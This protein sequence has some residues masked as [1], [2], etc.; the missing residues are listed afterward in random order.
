MLRTRRWF[1]WLL[2]IALA[3]VL[4]TACGNDE[5]QT[6]NQAP[7]QN[8]EENDDAGQALQGP[9]PLD[10]TSE[11]IIAEYAGGEVTEGEFNR[12]LNVLSLLD[13]RLSFAMG[14]AEVKK[15]LLNQYMAQELIAEREATTDEMEQQIDEYMDMMK[16]QYE[17]M[18]EQENQD[19]AGWLE[20]QG[21]NEEA[22]RLFMLNST[23][24]NN[25]LNGEVTDEDLQASYD[26]LSERD[27][28]SLY[29][30]KVRHI[31]IEVNEERDAEA[32]KERAEEVK[33]K[34]AEG[35][36][37]SELAK[38]FSDDGSSENGGLL[39]EEPQPLSNYVL[40]FAQTARDLALDEISEPVQSQFGFHIIDVEERNKI[41]FAEAKDSAQLRNAALD[42]V[43]E[44]FVEDEL[45][46][47][48]IDLPGTESAEA[49][50]GEEADDN[51]A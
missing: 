25:Y 21:V 9:E 6:E 28:V 30:A 12:S 14:Q 45:D 31:L 51:A 42:K 39:S 15:E 16:S 26:E 8:Q 48:K 3:T 33:G 38:E 29:E 49:P 43:F 27:D 7:E 4:F 34:L 47:T 5:G 44:R 32:A 20:D 24:L 36:D 35:G 18:P 37:F 2:T 13:P 1:V 22:I 41:A 50:S 17:Q 11:A 10:T 19:F 40:P 23:K 46:V